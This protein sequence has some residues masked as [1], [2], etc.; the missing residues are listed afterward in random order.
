MVLQTTSS[1]GKKVASTSNVGRGKPKR[2]NDSEGTPEG[3]K[4]DAEEDDEEDDE[5][6]EY[7]EEEAEEHF[8]AEDEDKY[9]RGRVE[10]VVDG[11]IA[12]SSS[13]E[14]EEDDD[15]DPTTVT[16]REQ[17]GHTG[18]VK[19][20]KQRP[21]ERYDWARSRAPGHTVGVPRTSNQP[22]GHTVG[23]GA[24]FPTGHTVGR[25]AALSDHH[26]DGIVQVRGMSKTESMRNRQKHFDRVRAFVKASVFRRIKF[27]NSD[28]MF[29]KAFKLVID[30][31]TVPP[32][33][34]G[35]FQKLYESVF[36][37]SLNTKRS[38]CEQAGGK[39]VRESIAIFKDQGEEEFFTIHE[40][41]KLRRATM[42]RE[43]KAFF[44]FFGTYLE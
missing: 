3:N 40:L 10:A 35:Q 13:N 22:T 37:E 42:E 6:Y 20:R 38:S 41:C 39:I 14:E 36:N 21:G 30:Q 8:E 33:Q 32:H 19:K 27:I 26:L 25:D 34:R 1:N 18:N 29:Q 15:D 23:G 31:E 4:E 12:N 9:E 2:D 16:D 44:W 28:I 7:H 17:Y 11:A 24:N 5:D 43:R